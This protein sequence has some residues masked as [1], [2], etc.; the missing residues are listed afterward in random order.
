M[1]RVKQGVLE[2]C[3]RNGIKRVMVDAVPSAT[4]VNLQ[5]VAEAGEKKKKCC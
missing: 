3:D 4:T 2:A 5:S 1:T